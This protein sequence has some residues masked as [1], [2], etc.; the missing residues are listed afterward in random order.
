MAGFDFKNHL[1]T[2]MAFW[3]PSFVTAL[4]CASVLAQAQAQG[5]SVKA[6]GL[7]ELT[8][9]DAT[10]G[11]NFDNGIK[12]AVKEV[13]AAGGILGRRIDY[14]SSDTQSSPGVAKGLA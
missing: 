9:T 10:S 3:K 8:G 7:V 5:Q 13:N 11:T 6:V 14:S 1:E 4:L 2:H 12:L